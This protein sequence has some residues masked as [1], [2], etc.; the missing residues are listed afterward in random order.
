MTGIDTKVTVLGYIQ[1]GGAPSIFDRI[2]ASQLGYLA[3]KEAKKGNSLAL[4]FK[5]GRA[6]AM[7]FDEIF[8]VKKV[9]RDDLLDILK[10]VS[11]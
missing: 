4:G 10:T 1:R 7:S 2:L 5:D 6:M 9:F 11:I 3:V 8:D